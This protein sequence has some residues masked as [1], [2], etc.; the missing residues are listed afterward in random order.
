MTATII[1]CSYLVLLLGLGV[2]SNKSFK[3]TT[4]DYFVASR[5]I[6][7]FLLLMSLFGTTMTAFALLGSTGE[8]YA[9]GIG[10]Y[11]KLASSS[12]I[13][14]AL[15]F[16]LIGVK[17]WSYGS[18]H[19]YLTQIQFFRD[20]FDSDKIGLLLFPCIVGLVIPYLLIGIIGAGSTFAKASGGIISY[21]LGAGIICVVVLIYIFA[22]GVRGTTWANCFQTI[23]FIVMGIITFTV[24]SSK[25]GGF[26]AATQAVVQNNP[27]KLQRAAHPDDVKRY[28]I[29]KARYDAATTAGETE[30]TAPKAPESISQLVFFTYMLIPLSVGMFPHIFQHWLTA[31]SANSFKLPIIA[32]PLLIMIVWVPCVLVGTWATSAVFNGTQVIPPG[33]HPMTVLV[34]MVNKMTG[35]ILGGFLT[36]GIMAAIMSSLD[37]QFLCLGSMFTN[38]I[39][40]HYRGDKGISEKQKVLVS[41]LF[42]VG[43]VLVTY[44][45]AVYLKNSRG[46]FTLGIWC[47]SGFS[48]LVPLVIAS[49]YW[50]RTTKAAA[51]ASIFAAAA[52]WLYLFSQSGYGANRAYLFMDMM[53]VATMM[54]AST[55]AL[56]VVS[57]STKPLKQTTL[58]KFFPAKG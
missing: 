31:R 9:H 7:P 22:G 50:R 49:L 38:D 51:Y 44:L 52:S 13:I 4:S 18:K 42:V 12:G 47:F 10:V 54:I 23:V 21:E 33:T 46:I 58:E 6:G 2:L 24:I 5:G 26:Q 30:L 36:A 1:I 25:L 8:S 37:S 29:A 39:Y 53:P 17:L 19:G 55:V 48:A 43:V 14:H 40:L 28:E 20:R 3:G 41:R 15:C 35:P 45:I 34:V 16:F 57:L 56:V 27:T 11:G 32:H